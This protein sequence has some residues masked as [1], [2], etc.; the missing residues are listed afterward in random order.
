MSFIAYLKTKLT[1]KSLLKI[2]GWACFLIPAAFLGFHINGLSG[3][4]F[5]ASAGVL[6]ASLSENITYKFLSKQI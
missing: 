2:A 5:G 6:F 3:L 4:F 1:K